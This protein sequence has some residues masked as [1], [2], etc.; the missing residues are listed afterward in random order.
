[1]ALTEEQL[2]Q[3]EGAI[4]GDK[5]N[6][7]AEAVVA[8]TALQTALGGASKVL[9]AMMARGYTVGGEQ[10]ISDED[11]LSRQFTAEE[12]HIVIELFGELR[13]LS[14]G[15]DVKTGAWGIANA[16]VAN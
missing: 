11:L 13:K 2:Q 14:M 3:K 1:M 8:S 10:E 12:F 4:A 7:I 9:T 15:A 6:L 5:A 16:K